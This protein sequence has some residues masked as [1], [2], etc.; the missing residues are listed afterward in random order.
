MANKE[1]IEERKKQYKPREKL[2][3]EKY[4]TSLEGS[5]VKLLDSCRR[6]CKNKK[7]QFDIDKEFIVDLVNKTIEKCPNIFSM[8][9]HSPKKI[10]IDQIVC[11]KGYT[12]DNVQIIP[13]WLNFAYNDYN[14]TEVDDAIIEYAEYLKNIKK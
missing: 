5:V 13:A 11:G 4:F 14:K 9:P 2:Y 7:L 10:S 12:Q 1:L 8:Q 6:R 3:R